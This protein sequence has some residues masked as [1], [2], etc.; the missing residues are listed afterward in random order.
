[1]P[2]MEAAAL[3]ENDLFCGGFT[4]QVFIASKLLTALPTP[5]LNQFVFSVTRRYRSDES[6]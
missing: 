1:M 5:N 2:P 3:C 6:Y 4:F